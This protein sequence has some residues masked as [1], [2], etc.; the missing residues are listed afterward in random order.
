[1]KKTYASGEKFGK[2]TIISSLSKRV[3]S[4]GRKIS[5]VLCKCDCGGETITTITKLRSGQMK[6][7]GCNKGFK[8]GMAN[9][10]EYSSWCN[11]KSRCNNKNYNRFSDYGGRGITMCKR[12]EKFDNFHF[13]M[14]VRPNGKTLDRV[15]NLKGYSKENCKW[16]TPKEQSNNTRRNHYIEYKGERKTVTDWEKFLGLNTGTLS[17]RIWRGWSIEKAIEKGR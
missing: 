7:C 2:L 1:M 5:S 13:D 6:S 8:H 10:R 15:D 4:T 11:M 17:T 3:G 16:S 12:W 14:G 9:S